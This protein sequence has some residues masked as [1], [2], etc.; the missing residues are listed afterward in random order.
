M[1][2]IK[3]IYPQPLNVNKKWDDPDVLLREYRKARAKIERAL[4]EDSELERKPLKYFQFNILG[5]TNFA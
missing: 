2:N 3:N 1:P 5:K 4:R